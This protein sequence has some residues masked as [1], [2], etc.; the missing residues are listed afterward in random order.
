MF[1][2]LIA[3]FALCSVFANSPVRADDCSPVAE[4]CCGSEVRGERHQLRRA[5]RKGPAVSQS[6]TSKSAPTRVGR[7]AKGPVASSDKAA[8]N[9]NP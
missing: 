6:T 1:R 5:S 8:G 7:R 4:P 9:N 2:G 3:L